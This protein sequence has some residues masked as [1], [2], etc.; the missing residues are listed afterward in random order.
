MKVPSNVTFQDYVSID[1][2]LIIVEYPTDEDIVITTINTKAND[3]VDSG[4]DDNNVDEIL[5]IPPPTLT[6]VTDN[7]HS[8]LRFVESKEDVPES[9]FSAVADIE[10]WLTMLHQMK[11]QKT[12]KDFFNRLL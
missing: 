7:L 10:N 6:E 8:V 4:P 11:H 2:D 9:V 12:I 3:T 5:V 1:E